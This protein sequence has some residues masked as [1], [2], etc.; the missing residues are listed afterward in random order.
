ME[1]TKDRAVGMIFYAA[2]QRM[3]NE[4]RFADFIQNELETYLKYSFNN[5]DLEKY[6]LIEF[7]NGFYLGNTSHGT[8][9][10]FGVRL[11]YVE[12]YNHNFYIGYWKD[13]EEHGEGGISCEKDTKTYFGGF[14]NGKYEGDG[15]IVKNSGLL[16]WAVFQQGEIVKVKQTTSGFSYGGQ[17]YDKNGKRVDKDSSC[18]GCI[19]IVIVIAL[20]FGVYSYC[21]S[22]LETQKPRKS[23]RTELYKSTTTYVCTARKSLIVRS[24]PN[25]SSRQIGSLNAREEVEVYEVV[26][27][28]AKIRFGGEYGYASIKYLEK[29]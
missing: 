3:K 16:F 22:W 26:D 5:D 23:Q 14:A 24:E 12:G 19:V 20:L 18:L 1:L 7:S 6:D 25:A 21:S 10:G 4:L 17:E 28:F 27:G 2:E 8:L 11:Y 15:H 9:N 13:G 29:K